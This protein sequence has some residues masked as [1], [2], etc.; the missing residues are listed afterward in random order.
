MA[1][2]R[3]QAGV[4]EEKRYDYKAIRLHGEKTPTAA[5][6]GDGRKKGGKTAGVEKVKTKGVKGTEKGRSGKSSQGEPVVAWSDFVHEPT[7]QPEPG[8]PDMTEGNQ[9][10]SSVVLGEREAEALR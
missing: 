5:G 9:W 10:W 4:I 6:S 1:R 7:P 2:T 3:T 8:R